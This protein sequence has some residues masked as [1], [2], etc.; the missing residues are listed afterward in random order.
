MQ[1]EHLALVQL[2]K[3][4]S[5]LR[6][7]INLQNMYV[8]ECRCGY[9]LEIICLNYHLCREYMNEVLENQNQ[10]EIEREEEQRRKENKLWRVWFHIHFFRFVSFVEFFYRAH[11]YQLN[12]EVHGCAYVSARVYVCWRVRIKYKWHIFFVFIT[13]SAFIQQHNNCSGSCGRFFVLCVN[14]RLP[15]ILP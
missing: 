10:Q 5:K 11:Y 13:F 15:L 1:T 8:H 14:N 2:S 6:K 9:Q 12:V 7:K 4:F 3:R